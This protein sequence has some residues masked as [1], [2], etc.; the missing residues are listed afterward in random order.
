MSDSVI[1]TKQVVEPIAEAPTPIA[2]DERSPVETHV[3]ELLATYAEDMGKPYT[4]TYFELDSVWDSE[5]TLSNE[6]RTIEG[7]M[8]SEIKKGN[9][10]NNVKAGEQYLREI[11]KKAETNPYESTTK[12]IQKILA[13]IEFRRVIDK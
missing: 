7:F 11:E 6:L 2:V 1:R 9:L 3:P 4:A 13:Y 12:R 10:E 5:P 8:Q